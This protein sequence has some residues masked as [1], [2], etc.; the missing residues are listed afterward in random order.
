MFTSEMSMQSPPQQTSL[1]SAT[2]KQQ[3]SGPG[4]G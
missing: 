2:C 4:T 1:A 3:Y